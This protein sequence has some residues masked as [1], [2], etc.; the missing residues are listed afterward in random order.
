[1]AATIC[2][3]SSGSFPTPEWER[4]Q[5]ALAQ[6]QSKEDKEE[7][8]LS[9]DKAKSN[10]RNG[11]KGGSEAEVASSGEEKNANSPQV[12]QPYD[13]QC[14]PPYYQQQYQPPMYNAGPM[15]NQQYNGYYPGQYAYPTP[16]G[17]SGPYG[18]PSRHMPPHY[19]PRHPYNHPPHP[20]HG[21][22]SA[23]GQS[24]E[25][26]RSRSPTEDVSG[27]RTIPPGI[28][29]H[30]HGPH[31]PFPHRPMGPHHGS[32]H[33]PPRFNFQD[34]QQSSPPWNKKQ[35]PGSG[36]IRFNLPKR[37]NLQ[38]GNAINQFQGRPQLQQQAS[39][40]PH[41]QQS[42]MQQQPPHRPQHQSSLQQQQPA[43]QQQQP[44]WTQAHGQNP[45]SNTSHSNTPPSPPSPQMEQVDKQETAQQLPRKEQQSQAVATGEWPPSLKMFVQ[46]CFSSVKDPRDKDVVE[47]LLR[48]KL[49][50]AFNSGV[51]QTKNWDNEALPVLPSSQG[52]NVASESHKS[53][54]QSS[55]SPSPAKSPYRG[56]GRNPWSSNN[57]F[58]RER[59]PLSRSR[60]PE[61]NNHS[62]ISRA[63]K[64]FSRSKSRSRSRSPYYRRPS[65]RRKVSR[66]VLFNFN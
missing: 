26:E 47:A 34:R 14:Y 42:T 25:S 33:F 54:K 52:P 30:S 13:Q 2:S 65:R 50:Q 58:R 57:T 59:S 19:P 20:M 39:Q 5:K 27:G 43:K 49:T 40:Q 56:K 29:P 21:G 31:A 62:H 4:A 12:S 55:W 28:G 32:S 45:T 60:T 18:A 17:V 37:N 51:A 44:S 36:A 16:P 35:A 64:R 9:L 11:E 3:E 63:P 66:Q 46:R 38:P 8:Q 6:L 22:H 41:Q 61:R 24:E 7:E 53:H 15:Y 23:D 1:M 48:E 10:E